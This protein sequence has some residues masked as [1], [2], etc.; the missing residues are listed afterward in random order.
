MQIKMCHFYEFSGVGSL[1][2]VR[3]VVRGL[4]W[5]RAFGDKAGSLQFR[6]GDASHHVPYKR[7][8]RPGCSL[9]AKKETLLILQYSILGQQQRSK[10]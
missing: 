4:E 2:V 10:S 8:H 6:G 1:V 3:G 7:P 9:L 5:G